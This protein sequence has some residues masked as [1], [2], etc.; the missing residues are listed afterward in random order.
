MPADTE[1]GIELK[2]SFLREG[3]FKFFGKHSRVWA[4]GQ[5]IC[6]RKELETKRGNT[7][8]STYL[9][10]YGAQ[11]TQQSCFSHMSWE[12]FGRLAQS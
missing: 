9:P 3:S 7:L 11:I 8:L 1:E 2:R 12:Q 10:T 5:K 6:Y 4:T